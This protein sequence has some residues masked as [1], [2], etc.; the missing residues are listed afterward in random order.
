MQAAAA[1]TGTTTTSPFPD[2]APGHAF[3]GLYNLVTRWGTLDD[4]E[5]AKVKGMLAPMA[6]RAPDDILVG[7]IESGW[8]VHKA[9]VCMIVCR[10]TK[11][12]LRNLEVWP[13]DAVSAIDCEGV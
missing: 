12:S 2:P 11:A 4:L 10:K 13:N 9:Y 6:G 1:V 7:V 3:G 8:V 5:V